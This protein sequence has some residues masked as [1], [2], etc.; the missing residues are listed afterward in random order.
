MW[1]LLYMNFNFKMVWRGRPFNDKT[2]QKLWANLFIVFESSKILIDGEGFIENNQTGIILVHI[3]KVLAN[4]SNDIL[5][6]S[7]NELS[8]RLCKKVFSKQKD[9]SPKSDPS[10]Q[11]IIRHTKYQSDIKKGDTSEE[12]EINNLRKTKEEIEVLRMYCKIR[13]DKL[14][15]MQQRLCLV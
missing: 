11:R 4:T 12:K 1:H 6:E 7:G 8:E 13:A 3:E 14:P 2:F 10:L 15:H 5:H 9:V